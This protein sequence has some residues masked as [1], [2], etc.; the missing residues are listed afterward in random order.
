VQPDA[1]A[2]PYCCPRWAGG[3][4]IVV[5]YLVSAR[6]GSGTSERFPPEKH[7]RPGSFLG[8]NSGVP[9]DRAHLAP[10]GALAVENG[11]DGGRGR[12]GILA[13]SPLPGLPPAS[14]H[15]HGAGGRGPA[16]E[17]GIRA[18]HA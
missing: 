4:E 12:S 3:S 7:P 6:A 5:E 2:L 8:L 17:R 1:S 10:E 14:R 13:S 16:G 18:V 11:F 9:Q 15:G